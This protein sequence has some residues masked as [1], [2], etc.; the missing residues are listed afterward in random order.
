MSSSFPGAPLATTISDSRTVFT[1]RGRRRG[2]FHGRHPGRLGP[3]DP[4]ALAGV[5]MMGA[6]KAPADGV[7]C[8]PCG[9][10]GPTPDSSSIPGWDHRVSPPQAGCPGSGRLKAVCVRRFPCQARRSS[11]GWRLGALR[12]RREGVHSDVAQA[13]VDTCV[14]QTYLLAGEILQIFQDS[15]KSDPSDSAPMPADLGR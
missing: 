7:T 11:F 6:V 5:A 8:V 3:G 12:V 1:R 15:S 13:E 4:E 14:M 2:R 10:A 9:M